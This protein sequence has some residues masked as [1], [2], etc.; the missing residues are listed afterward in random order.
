MFVCSCNYDWGVKFVVLRNKESAVFLLPLNVHWRKAEL[1]LI[2]A[3]C[4]QY[5]TIYQWG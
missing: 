2:Q 3:I 1:C 5:K 4:L